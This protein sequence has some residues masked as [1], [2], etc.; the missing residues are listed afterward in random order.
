[1]QVG[2]VLEDTNAAAPPPRR[3][4]GSRA[5]ETGNVEWESMMRVATTVHDEG[6]SGEVYDRRF[7]VKCTRLF[8]F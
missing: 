2:G 8:G 7:T 4:E 6:W 3:S 1:M 5:A